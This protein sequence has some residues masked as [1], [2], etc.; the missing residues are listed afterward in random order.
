MSGLLDEATDRTRADDLLHAGAPE[1]CTFD[2]FDAP[3]QAVASL[4]VGD[5]DRRLLDVQ[6]R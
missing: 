6:S 5:P 1:S 4:S 3:G 2:W